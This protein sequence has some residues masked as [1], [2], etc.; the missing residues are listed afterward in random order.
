MQKIRVTIWNEYIHEKSDPVVARIYPEGIHEAIA[1]YLR[2]KEDLEIGVA[3]LEEPEH[4]L[5]EDRL[6]STDVLIWW[7]HR[8]HDRVSDEVVDRVHRR[9]VFEGMGLIILHSAHL[10]KIFR[11]L[12]G[13]SCRLKW[14]EAGER[15][16]V[17]VV[18]PWHPIAD[19]L[20]EYF[21]IEHSE[22]Y[23]E[24]FDI[25]PPDQLVFISW[26]KGG[27][28]FRSGCCFHRGMG[29]IFYFS[30]GHETYPIYYNPSVRRVIYNAILWAKPV[31]RAP[32]VF[33]R[34]DPLEKL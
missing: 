22:M 9:V 20:G 17:W 25:P 34:V 19:G 3:T 26:F 8:A 11:R 2:G 29:R 24:P 5:T 31:R 6:K 32:P 21:E 1:E 10:S 13:T 7:G 14:R 28:V 15:E 30:P 23:G 16:R 4:G 12:M 18:A 33:G 27:E